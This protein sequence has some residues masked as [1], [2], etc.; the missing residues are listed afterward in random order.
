MNTISPIARHP[1]AL[2]IAVIAAIVLLAG[3]QKIEFDAG[4]GFM[5][6]FVAG[7]GRDCSI[8]SPEAEGH[9]RSASYSRGYADGVGRGITACNAHRQDQSRLVAVVDTAAVRLDAR[10][11]YR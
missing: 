11:G 1:T 3:C 4:A 6:G 10:A 9:W 8:R 2:R 5:D 7:Y